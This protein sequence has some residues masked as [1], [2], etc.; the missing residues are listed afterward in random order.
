M[1]TIITNVR[2]A[3]NAKELAANIKEGIQTLDVMRNAVDRTKESLS[4]QGLFA[5]ANRATVA[6]TELG[7]ATRLTAAEAERYNAILDK[8]IKKAEVM[9]R[10]VPAAWREVAADTKR[11]AEAAQQGD[12]WHTKLGETIRLNVPILGGLSARITENV[13]VLGALGAAV[14]GVFV[15]FEL[16]KKAFDIA[17]S[18]GQ[19]AGAI[20]DLSTQTGV[21]IEQLQIL[22]A[23]TKDYGV[24]AEE[25]G[26]GMFQ[27][28]QR[29]AGGDDSAAAA[30]HVLGLRV[31]ELKGK[32]PD[33]IFLTA[34]RAINQL[35]NPLTRSAVAAELFGSKLA[36]AILKIGPD[37][38]EMIAKVKQAGEFMSE[39]AV[40]GADDFADA[41]EHLKNQ[42]MAFAGDAL[43][44]TLGRLT[45]LLDLLRRPEIGTLA[46]LFMISQFPLADSLAAGVLGR[47]PERPA[48]IA[49][50]PSHGPG[51]MPLAVSHGADVQQTQQL[52]QAITDLL[53]AQ[54]PLTAEDEKYLKLLGATTLQIA[55]LK[56]QIT[57]H[58]QAAKRLAEANRLVNDAS[59]S[60]G[61]VLATIKPAVAAEVQGLMLRGQWLDAMAPKYGL[62][63][64]QVKAL[65]E[66]LKVEKAISDLAS[67]ATSDL[68]AAH[69]HLGQVDNAT[70]PLLKARIQAEEQ[71]AQLMAEIAR[72]ES[73][74]GLPGAVDAQLLPGDATNE[75]GGLNAGFDKL[76]E[77]SRRTHEVWQLLGNDLGL[78][79][80]SSDNWFG[81][82][83]R[84]LQ[85]AI[86]LLQEIFREVLSINAA[87]AA[88]S[89]LKGIGTGLAIGLAFLST[90]GLF[91]SAG[92]QHFDRGGIVQNLATPNW[93]PPAGVDS[94]IVRAFP[95]EMLITPMQQGRLMNL[96]EGE[97]IS[98]P[99]SGGGNWETHYHTHSWDLRQAVVTSDQGL[100]R[101]ARE[102]G[103]RSARWE[104]QNKDSV[105][106]RNRAGYGLRS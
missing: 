64:Q 57:E 38:D 74:R 28:S 75:L 7:G 61:A 96:I 84:A 19:T 60:Y 54:R 39:D 22:G 77:A 34:V 33:Q 76:N 4:G 63:E 46:K 25:L 90:G 91:T 67:K 66:Q 11:A 12:A 65:A 58:I 88:G 35:P 98:L 16:L 93:A 70:I 21:G 51:A 1:A 53:N 18:I 95:G 50:M 62:N 83:L 80:E 85:A 68:A 94:Q 3:D 100:D 52:K 37:L 103:R 42:M 87:A 72:L 45:L 102:V 105:N 73:G 99:T 32:S 2:F 9:G 69:E 14:G 5:A 78:L 106:T 79:A 26:R 13:A 59:T 8:A 82:M 30:L 41:I 104:S 48:P 20:R 24:T 101:L 49:P 89:V 23:A 10:E 29:I 71:H 27:L 40:K 43:G 81:R 55:T 56:Q 6:I 44:P 97:G 31:D 15:G 17:L 86:P 36:A 47:T 92:V